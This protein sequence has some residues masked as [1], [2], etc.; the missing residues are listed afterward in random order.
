MEIKLSEIVDYIKGRITPATP[1]A[2]QAEQ[3]V[4]G[5]F[6]GMHPH[7]HL[8]IHFHFNGEETDG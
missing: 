1:E 4:R 7:F 3:P 8:N 6:D 2:Q 5:L